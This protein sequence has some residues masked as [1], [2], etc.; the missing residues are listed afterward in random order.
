MSP[1]DRSRFPADCQELSDDALYR[2]EI[3]GLTGSIADLSR[4]IENPA[5][6][7]EVV[8]KLRGALAFMEGPSS[9]PDEVGINSW[10]IDPDARREV[11]AVLN[12]SS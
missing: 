7:E 10:E 1:L 5:V 11:A 8:A 9:E 2:I 3:S 6:L 12:P 4:N